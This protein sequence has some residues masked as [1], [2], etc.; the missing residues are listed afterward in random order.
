M[1][2]SKVDHQL[3]WNSVFSNYDW[4][5]RLRTKENK[6]GNAHWSTKKTP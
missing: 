3:G 5:K 2:F 4:M 6:I 1:F